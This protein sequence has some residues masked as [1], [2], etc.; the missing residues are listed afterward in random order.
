MTEIEQYEFDRQGYI[1]IQNMLTDT[2][3]Q[4]LREAVGKLE[5]HALAHVDLPPRK[6][7]AWGAEYHANDEKG[8]Y[9]QGSNAEEKTLIIEDFWNADPAFDGLVSHEKTSSYVE[10]VINGR[11]TINNSEIRIRYKGNASRSHGGP[12]P[13][14]PKGQALA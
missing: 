14:H 8:Y 2:E 11:Y 7:S 4:S 12:R 9:V 1:I 13:M 6:L 3:V 5:K 10:A